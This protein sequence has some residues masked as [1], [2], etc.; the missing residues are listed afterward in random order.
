MRQV[1]S[2]TLYSMDLSWDRI[3]GEP[4]LHRHELRKSTWINVYSKLQNAVRTQY[5][6]FSRRG[7]HQGKFQF[8]RH[9]FKSTLRR[10]THREISWSACPVA[11]VLGRRGENMAARYRSRFARVRQRG[12]T[13]LSCRG[14]LEFHVRVRCWT[15]VSLS[16]PFLV[17][18]WRLWDRV[19][20][21]VACP[22][23]LST[24]TRFSCS[25]RCP[26]PD[27]RRKRR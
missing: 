26:D 3:F 15:C 7:D 12:S 6:F 25:N 17:A 21:T 22:R 1:V 23:P 24:S 5:G 9:A 4:H 14:W 10:K 2:G 20:S 16:E 19:L 18:R 13:N 27:Q 11:R 8:F